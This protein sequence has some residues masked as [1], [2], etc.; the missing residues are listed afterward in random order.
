MLENQNMSGLS[1]NKRNFTFSNRHKKSLFDGFLSVLC[2]KVAHIKLALAAIV[3][4]VADLAKDLT[5][6]PALVVD[7]ADG[8]HAAW[9]RGKNHKLKTFKIEAI[10]EKK[11][12]K[13]EKIRI[14]FNKVKLYKWGS[15]I[16]VKK[17]ESPESI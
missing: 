17:N 7:A 11:V 9:G 1:S 13:L 14:F 6:G 15:Q 2:F 5:L 16:D 12:L 3:V 4:H 8:P 10:E